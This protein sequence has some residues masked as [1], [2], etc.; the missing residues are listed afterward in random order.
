MKRLFAVAIL[1]S[2]CAYASTKTGEVRYVSSGEPQQHDN[3]VSVQQ[4]RMA[5]PPPWDASPQELE[6]KGDDL[7]GMLARADALD[8]YRAALEKTPKK[9]RSVLYNKCGIAELHMWRLDDAQ[10]DF[11][12]SIKLDKKYADAMNNLG[13]V[14]FVKGQQDNSGGDY[15]KAIKIYQ[16]A[17]EL[18]P[19]SASFHANLGRAYSAHKE[20]QRAEQEYA[21]ALN[22]D[23]DIFS[24]ESRGGIVARMPQDKGLLD[25]VLAKLLASHGKMDEALL[26]LRRAMEEGY[27]DVNKVYTDPEFA[28]LIKDPRFT[29]MMNAH[30]A[31]QPMPPPK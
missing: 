24:R 11:V 19:D 18:K 26:Y 15:K 17:I 10:R 8:Y 27:K 13:V 7:L 30:N 2:A 21:V 31:G 22:L 23:P 5:P 12:R 16:K 1:F 20:G 25:Y 6:S 9:Q 3:S 14:Y 29:E 4:W 28:K